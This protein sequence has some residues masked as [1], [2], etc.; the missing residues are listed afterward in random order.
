M[1]EE[2]GVGGNRI[3][4]KKDK[5]DKEKTRVVGRDK[6]NLTLSESDLNMTKCVAALPRS[7]ATSCDYSKDALHKITP[8]LSTQNSSS[9]PHKA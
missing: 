7:P 6:G 5:I 4:I 9:R 3:N 2:S 8:S 1:A